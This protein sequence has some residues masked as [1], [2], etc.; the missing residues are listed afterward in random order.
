LDL[1]QVRQSVARIKTSLFKNSNAYSVGM[2]RS[3]FRGGGLQFKDHQPYVHGDDVRFLDWK[4]YAKTKVAHM[5]TFEE[6][7]NVEIVVVI[8]TSPTM[9]SG[10]EGISKLQAAIEICCLLYILSQETGDF[11]HTVLWGGDLVNLPKMSGE[12]GIVT[13]IATLERQG[14]LDE[15]G[16]VRLVNSLLDQPIRDHREELATLARHLHK[17]R[18]IVMLSDF[19]GGIPLDRLERYLVRSTLHCFRLLS[20]LDLATKVP[21]LLFTKDAVSRKQKLNQV[22][23]DHQQNMSTARHRIKDLKID[24]RYLEAFIKEM[25]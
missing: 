19:M 14:V 12:Q 23:M 8:D 20:P 21:Y 25:L 17:K 5:K 11:V 10:H 15:S 1:N 18:E 2:L 9:R 13:L 4:V 24:Q 7:R 3:H 6:E 16:R 22:L